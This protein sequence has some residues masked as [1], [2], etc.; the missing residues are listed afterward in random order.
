MTARGFSFGKAYE[1]L[2]KIVA[3]FESRELDLERD[4]PRFEQG[5][6]LAQQLRVR[7]RQ[8]ENQVVAIEQKFSDKLEGP[9]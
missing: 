5:L 1:E 6:K 2:E 8:I 4:I 9:S 7:L 3:D